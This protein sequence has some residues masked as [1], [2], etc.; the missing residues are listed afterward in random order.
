VQVHENHNTCNAHVKVSH[1][2]NPS[3]LQLPYNVDKIIIAAVLEVKMTLEFKVLP[4]NKYL[5]IN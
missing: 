2:H 4:I 1:W 5:N 3:T